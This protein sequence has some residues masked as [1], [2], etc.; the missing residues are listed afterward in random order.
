[1][2]NKQP[3]LCSV[4]NDVFRVK[5]AGDSKALEVIEYRCGRRFLP[6]GTLVYH[7]RY[8]TKVLGKARTIRL[9]LRRSG[10]NRLLYSRRIKGL[11]EFFLQYHL[12][13]DRDCMEV[14]S[15]FVCRAERP[16]MLGYYV[17]AI[18]PP[19]DCDSLRMVA[20]A[21]GG[22]TRNGTTILLS[23]IYDEA[24]GPR[25]TASATDMARDP[26]GTART[27]YQYLVQSF[28]PAYAEGAMSLAPGEEVTGGLKI[29]RIREHIWDP[30][31]KRRQWR[32]LPAPHAIE[33]PR[34]SLGRY[35]SNW[36]RYA[37][38]PSLWVQLGEDMGMHHVGFYGMLTEA[39]LGGPY[40]WALNGRPVRYG[41]L[42]ELFFGRRRRRFRLE[43]FQENIRQLEIAWG[44]GGNAMVAYAYHL[45]GA[46][47]SRRMARQIL[48]AILGLRK[49]GFQI[50]SGPLAGAWINAYDADARR[51]QDH[52]GGRQ[53]FL[54]DQGIVNYF[55]S[56]CYLEGFCDDE[57]I[58]EKIR[59]NCDEFLGRIEDKYGTYPNAFSADGSIGYSRE[60]YR[61]D[62]PNAPGL[63]LTMLSFLSCYELTGEVEYL[64]LAGDVLKRW[65]APRIEAFQFGFLEYDHG[66]WDSAGACHMLIALGEYLR[67]D[68]CPHKSL[69]DRIE[70]EVFDY[71]MS[72]R[73]EH[74]YFLPAHSDNVKGWQAVARNKF[75][76]IHGF[77]PGSAQGMTVLHLRY[78]FGYALMRAFQTR[79]GPERYAAFMNYLNMYTYQQFLNGD[80]PVGFGGCTEHTALEPYVQDTTHVIHS[81]PLAM[82]ALKRWGAFIAQADR[83]LKD[84]Q[85]IEGG[86][87]IELSGPT[88][89]VLETLCGRSVETEKG[90]LPAGMPV[91]VEKGR[92]RVTVRRTCPDNEQ[93]AKGR[94]E[95]DRS[96]PRS[97]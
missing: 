74:D 24:L 93:S 79:P 16:I 27:S 94:H 35:I 21:Y 57:R 13:E 58:I 32:R 22:F 10:G 75:G 41:E 55:L 81:T 14:T 86:L 65:L 11:G 36:Q 70:R 90:V 82:I 7:V 62:W 31:V 49:T 28:P 5:P 26:R 84:V 68:D 4:S 47:W 1:M 2:K 17:F 92:Q 15:R 34:F 89:L 67:H 42:R 87:E 85:P 20:G 33:A 43:G 64:Q 18:D 3:S 76:F 59:T 46:P 71:L 38:E 60:G 66:G 30:D 61:Y 54:P 53:V 40:G 48:N 19:A 23:D 39:K 51:F 29:E 80:L 72:F 25:Q 9:T 52:Y 45:H 6:V 56:R 95:A 12:P 91:T 8:W 96:R 69:A 83:P 44:N 63:A 77:T 97:R 88:R 37:Q 50:P 78:E 73:H